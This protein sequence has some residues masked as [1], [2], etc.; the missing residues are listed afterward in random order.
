MFAETPTT[1]GTAIDS[2]GN[3]YYSDPDNYRILKITPSAKISTLI[4]DP[5]LIWPDAMWIDDEGYLWIPCTQVNRTE[6]FNGGQ[7]RVALPVHVF[8]MKIDAKPSPIDH[9]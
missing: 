3:I 9:P 5:R 1:G 7:S 2:E 4:T 6:P 8:K